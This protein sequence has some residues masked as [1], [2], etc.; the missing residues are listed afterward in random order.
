MQR[1]PFAEEAF[2]Y[3]FEK[4][5]LYADSLGIGTTWVA[6]TMNRATFE[7]VMEVGPDEVLPSVS[8]LGYPAEKMSSREKILRTSVKADKRK[9]FETL[10][11]DGS[12]DKPLTPDTAGSL[13]E[14]LEMVRLAPSAVNKQPWR[15]VVDG[16][17]AH[18][19]EAHA[20]GYVDGTGWDMQKLDIGIAMYHFEL[21]LKAQGLSVKYAA[22][23]PGLAVGENTEYIISGTFS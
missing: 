5:I 1:A 23:D 4:V 17:T 12:F 19:Y 22:N 14:P 7:R 9:D 8:P 21:G 13:A 2:G 3:S 15:I 18:F 6:G 20:K 10:F 16:N 11:F